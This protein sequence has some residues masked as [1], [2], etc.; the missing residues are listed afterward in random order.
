[1]TI[2][3]ATS[4]GFKIRDPIMDGVSFGGGIPHGSPEAA[5]AIARARERLNARRLTKPQT[6]QKECVG[7]G[8][9]Y[10]ARTASRRWCD[11]CKGVKR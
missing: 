9:S 10:E 7:C 5:E 1:M 3:T 6:W 4:F 11:A 2:P 8:A